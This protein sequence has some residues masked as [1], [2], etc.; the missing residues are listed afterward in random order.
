MLDQSDTDAGRA[1]DLDHSEA[2]PFYDVPEKLN[3]F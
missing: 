1:T 3:Y 2:E